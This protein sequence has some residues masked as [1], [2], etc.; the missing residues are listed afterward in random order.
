MTSEGIL[1]QVNADT[2]ILIQSYAV[3]N[4]LGL[5][6]LKLREECLEYQEKYVYPCCPGPTTGNIRVDECTH[7]IEQLVT[8]GVDAYRGEFPH[9]A[10]LGYGN[11]KLEWLC[12][13]VIIS[14]RYVLTAGHCTY[15]SSQ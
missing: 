12:G 10:L 2:V 11:D 5:P 3:G 6:H 7:N 4:H 1:S 14:E 15:S 13:G 8:G 9:M